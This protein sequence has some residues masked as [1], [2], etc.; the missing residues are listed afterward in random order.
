MS[1]FLARIAA[2]A[3]LVLGATGLSQAAE[4]TVSAASSLT[5]AFKDIAAA[6][7]AQHPGTR[8]LLNFGA[9]G[10]LLQQIAKGAPV[11]V[12][13]SADQQTMDQAERQQLLQPGLRRNFVRN[14]LVVIVPQQAAVQP[15]SLPDLRQPGIARVAVGTPASVP[16]GRY[17][18]AVLDK[19]GLWSAIGAKAVNAAS[20][21]QALDYVARGEADAGFVYATDAALMPDKVRVAF[22]VPTETPVLYPIAPLAGST[23]PDEASRFVS[24]VLSPPA[25]AILVKYGFAR[26]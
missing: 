7:E 13:A 12:F 16:V 25:Q 24:F 20:V 10:A 14:A 2:G 21:R 9:S 17:T 18:Q 1:R 4:L 19:A 26:P 22:A 23:Q 5:Q 6:Y 11:D 8:V 3:L 15:K